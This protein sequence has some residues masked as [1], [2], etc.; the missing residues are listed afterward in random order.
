MQNQ[1]IR[2]F[3]RRDL[4]MLIVIQVPHALNPNSCAAA[5]QQPIGVE[6]AASTHRLVGS[7]GKYLITPATKT[8]W[9]E[10]KKG[11]ST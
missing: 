6:Y 10:K 4:V 9:R 2:I 7:T 8:V 1:R 5:S 11:Q 3:R